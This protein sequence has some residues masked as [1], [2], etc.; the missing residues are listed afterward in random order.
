MQ[1]LTRNKWLLLGH[2]PWL[3]KWFQGFLDTLRPVAQ[4]LRRGSRGSRPGFWRAVGIAYLA[5][6]PQSKRASCLGGRIIICTTLCKPLK[7]R[8]A[9]AKLWANRREL[10]VSSACPTRPGAADPVNEP[11]VRGATVSSSVLLPSIASPYHLP[12]VARLLYLLL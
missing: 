4:R 3:L 9:K 12:L 7:D 11:S 2:I 5:V 6:H 1:N 10:P 8:R